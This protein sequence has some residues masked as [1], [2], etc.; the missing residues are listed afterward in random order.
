MPFF[1]ASTTF[2]LIIKAIYNY[3]GGLRFS[4]RPVDWYMLFDLLCLDC[5]LPLTSYVQN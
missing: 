4:P 2:N 3:I 5:N 1:L